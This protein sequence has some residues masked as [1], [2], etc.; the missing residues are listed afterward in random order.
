MNNLVPINQIRDE[1]LA[2]LEQACKCQSRSLDHLAAAG[3]RLIELK[4]R[5]AHGEWGGWVEANLPIGWR[6]ANKLMRLAQNFEWVAEQIG[7]GGTNL[8]IN[9][10]LALIADCREDADD[11]DDGRADS[12]V[13]VIV[14]DADKMCATGDLEAL[15]DLGMKFQVIYADPPWAYD[16]QATRA[17]TDNHYPTMSLEELAELPIA[18]LAGEN[19]RLYLWTT[20]GFLEASFD[21]MRAWGFEPKSGMV[22]CKRQMGIGNY[23]RL[24]HEHLRIG[25]RGKTETRDKG[26]ISWLQTDRTRHSAKPEDFRRLIERLSPGPYLE[27]FGRRTAHGW[28]VWGNEIERDLFNADLEELEPTA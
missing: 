21:L 13:D 19:C 11:A 20:E 14:P 1:C 5:V 28:T 15:I 7:T 3:E 8:G 26:V 9:Q 4:S 22:W 2:E 10:A 27:L 25:V 18:K 17:A 24:A 12:P 16:N 6:Q 23:V